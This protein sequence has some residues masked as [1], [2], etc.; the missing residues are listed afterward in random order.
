MRMSNSTSCAASKYCMGCS[1]TDTC[2]TCFNWGSGKVGAR[3]LASNTC[4]ATLTRTVT[5]AKAYSGTHTNTSNFGVGSCYCKDSKYNYVDQTVATP[6]TSTC[7]KT[8][9]S[10]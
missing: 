8:S 5:D 10:G 7:S 9:I 3:S 2:S 6:Y 4:T 1:A